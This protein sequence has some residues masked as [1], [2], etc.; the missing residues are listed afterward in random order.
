VPA[1]ALAIG[2]RALVVLEELALLHVVECKH[3]LAALLRDAQVVE[4]LHAGQSPP[5][6]MWQR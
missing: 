5:A 3:V 2:A 1:L 6:Q 4:E